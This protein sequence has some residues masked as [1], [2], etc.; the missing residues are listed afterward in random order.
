MRVK[1]GSGF[2]Y[3]EV[4]SGTTNPASGENIAYFDVSYLLVLLLPTVFIL[5]VGLLI[6]KRIAARPE[7]KP[8]I[9]VYRKGYKVEKEPLAIND[10]LM[11]CEFCGVEINKHLKKCPNCQRSLK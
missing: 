6:F 2:F 1:S 5:A 8:F 11:I 9:N 4:E 3:I 7:R 10:D